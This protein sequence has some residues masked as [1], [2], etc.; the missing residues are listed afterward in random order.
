[1]EHTGLFLLTL[2]LGCSCVS[3]G[4][5]HFDI[6][7]LVP[8]KCRAC[9]VKSCPLLT[10]CTG[11]VVKDQCGCC[12]RCSS[13][14]FQSHVQRHK[15]HPPEIP[16]ANPPSTTAVSLVQ[17][18]EK[19]KC[20]RSNLCEV[21]Q[22]GL[23]ICTCP[24]KRKRIRRYDKNKDEPV[25]ICG[26]NGVTYPSR[27]HLK[28]ANC[29]SKRRIKR[30]HDGVCTGDD[31]TGL[32]WEK[33]EKAIKPIN[34]IINDQNTNYVDVQLHKEDQKRLRGGKR[35]ESKQSRKAKQRKLMNDKL[36]KN[37]KRRLRNSR[38]ERR[39]RD[40][41]MFQINNDRL[42]ERPTQWSSSQIRKS[43]I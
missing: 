12:Q 43:K 15:P 6:D 39:N 19:R 16:T 22:Q 21:N 26:T 23:P 31:V 11:I 36:S 28:I 8:P 1:M 13:D 18:H 27:C 35:K 24:S 2:Y 5:Y 34:N 20:H 38:M 17:A 3:A 14:L 37:N 30:K 42:L 33:N 29:N 40:N 9:D 25:E 7:Y 41:T 10:F 4:D 32:N